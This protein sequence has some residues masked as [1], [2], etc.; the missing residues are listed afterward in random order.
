L[1]QSET[2]IEFCKNTI[3]ELEGHI[4][5]YKNQIDELTKPTEQD[6]TEV[7]YSLPRNGSDLVR[8]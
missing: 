8:M 5:Q 7:N 6:V 2:E 3:T 4:E 1:Q